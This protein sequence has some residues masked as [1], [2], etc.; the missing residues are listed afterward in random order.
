M[1]QV[2]I[3]QVTPEQLN[4]VVQDALKLQFDEFKKSFEPKQPDEIYS[5]EETS[6]LLKIST[7]T[8]WRWTKEGKIK[9]HGIGGRTYYKKSDIDNALKPFNHE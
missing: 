8:L 7:V 5:P 9:A 6:E 4:Q 3:I 1:T 2:Q